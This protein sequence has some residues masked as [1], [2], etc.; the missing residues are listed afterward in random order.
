M[1]PALR[2]VRCGIIDRGQPC[3]VLRISYG[4]AGLALFGHIAECHAAVLR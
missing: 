3:P 2:V 4:D 1:M